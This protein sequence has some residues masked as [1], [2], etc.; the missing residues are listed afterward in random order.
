[1]CSLADNTG[2]T[3]KYNTAA[4][5][6]ERGIFGQMKDGGDWSFRKIADGE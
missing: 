3:L 2:G 6:M 1:M 5:F 4:E